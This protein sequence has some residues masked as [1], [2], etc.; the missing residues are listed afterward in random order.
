MSAPK[1]PKTI[2]LHYFALLREQAQRA[3][4]ERSTTACTYGE[5]YQE[6][7]RDYGFTLPLAQMKVAVNDT[8][9]ELSSAVQEGAE[10]V[11]IPPVAGG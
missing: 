7:Q 5:L 3:Q 8:F 9:V 6:L 1:V 10:V 11:F 2:R 4:E